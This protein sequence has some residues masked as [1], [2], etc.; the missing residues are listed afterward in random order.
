MGSSRRVASHV[1]TSP[2]PRDIQTE[3]CRVLSV[4]SLWSEAW[5]YLKI[6][7]T[8]T[9]GH[10]RSSDLPSHRKDDKMQRPEDGVEP[11]L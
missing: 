4:A 2:A 10:L 5:T 8:Y 7:S 3:Y 1:N 9:G 6:L 11:N